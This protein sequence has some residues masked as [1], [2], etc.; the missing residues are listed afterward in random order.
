MGTMSTVVQPPPPMRSL[1]PSSDLEFLCFTTKQPPQQGR[2]TDVGSS[3]IPPADPKGEEACQ[4]DGNNGDRG[5]GTGLLVWPGSRLL[6]SFLVDPLGARRCFPRVLP[7]SRSGSCEDN[8]PARRGGCDGDTILFDGGRKALDP[9]T[10][11]QQSEPHG[12]VL[13]ELEAEKEG[14]IH[15]VLGDKIGRAHV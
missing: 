2:P 4:E 14:K 1:R 10:T 7:T 12:V 3:A 15:L 5:D 9:S 13:P 8:R 11:P 6:A